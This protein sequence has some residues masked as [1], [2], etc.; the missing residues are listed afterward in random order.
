MVGVG[1]YPTPNSR[2]LLQNTGLLK[3]CIFIIFTGQSTPTSSDALFGH[4]LMRTLHQ[5]RG[6]PSAITRLHAI[7]CH[8]GIHKGRRLACAHVLHEIYILE[9][10]LVLEV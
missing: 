3:R 2:C 8:A 1:P 6:T 5:C 10:L 9:S 4:L 7:F